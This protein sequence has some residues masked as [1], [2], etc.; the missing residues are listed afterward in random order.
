MNYINDVLLKKYRKSSKQKS[1]GTESSVAVIYSHKHF[2]LFF[3]KSYAKF[4]IT[5]KVFTALQF[6][7]LLYLILILFWE[8]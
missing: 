2:L 3:A 6:I 4:T 8:T 5:K 1:V 7:C